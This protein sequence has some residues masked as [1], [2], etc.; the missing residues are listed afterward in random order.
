MHTTYPRR[1]VTPIRLQIGVAGISLA[2]LISSLF[3]QEVP[4]APVQ[5][6][7]QNQPMP[8][9]Q[10]LSPASLQQL[11]SPIALYPDALIALILPASTV[12][13]DVVLASRFVASNGNP[14]QIRNQSWDN[15]VQSLASYP[16]VVTWMDK[17]LEWT[18]SLGLAF[19]VQPADVM[20]AIQQLRAQAQA[21]GNLVDTPQQVIVKERTI[22]RIVP[23]EP[24]YLYVPQYDPE[25]VYVQPY[26]QDF[27]PLIT[28]GIGFAVGSWLNYDF[29]WNRHEIYRGDWQPG[30]GW[31]RNGNGNR[32]GG[33]N[34]VNNNVNNNVNVVNINQSTAQPWQA[35]S[36][37]RNQLKRQ[38]ENFQANSGNA[39]DA[40]GVVRAKRAGDQALRVPKPSRANIG[41]RNEGNRKELATP[42]DGPEAPTSP[43]VKSKNPLQPT[44]APD[45]AGQQGKPP[46]NPNNTNAGQDVNMQ[47]QK[48]QKSDDRPASPAV[49]APKIPA[50]TQAGDVPSVSPT[51]KQRGANPSTSAEVPQTTQAPVVDQNGLIPSRAAQPAPGGKR[52]PD[53]SS[54]RP[55]TGSPANQPQPSGNTSGQKNKNPDRASYP[56]TQTQAPQPGP[57]NNRQKP[58]AQPNQPPQPSQAPKM[59]T[60]GQANNPAPRQKAQQQ[61]QRPQQQQQQ[62]KQK[63]QQQPQQQ[64]PQQQQQPKQKPQ[65]QRPQSQPQQQPAKHQEQKA[66]PAAKKDQAP[67]AAS[68]AKTQAAPAGI[69]SDKYKDQDKK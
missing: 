50:P 5:T 30:W 17:N 45:V 4:P 15:S 60:D 52:K 13:S 26:S 65:Q 20:N 36:R 62:P 8:A 58:Q 16:D 28:F 68:P 43:V 66:A 14:A 27:G 19:L 49:Q 37:S 35:S 41:K 25:I 23:A 1:S 9:P 64:R 12:P 18:T 34:I 56:P 69:K 11:L 3:S 33:V 46:R 7:P 10:T 42:Q 21:A 53:P 59:H 44:T 51:K 24:D 67:N 29:D 47:G 55:Q 54:T 2:S 40:S 22:I 48:S 32:N 31:D 39:R 38:Q 6:Y 61:Q 57:G 63:P